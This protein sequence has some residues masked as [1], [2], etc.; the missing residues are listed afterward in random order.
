MATRV[1]CLGNELVCDDGIGIRVGRVLRALKLPDD[2]IVE[3]RPHVGLEMMQALGP[4]EELVLID[5]TVTGAPP[6]TCRTLVIEEI[7]ALAQRPV[8][9]HGL[10]VGELIAAAKRLDPGRVPRRVRLVGVEAQVLDRF[11][12]S[13]SPALRDALP[14]AVVATLRC[15]GSASA[16]L[17]QGRLEAERWKDWEPD[18]I[19]TGE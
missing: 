14:G 19:E 12:T 10:G 1:V 4:E 16:L 9:C 13:L 18:A 5:A 15:L 17:Q 11:G 3:L 7:E 8:C 2:V 6:G